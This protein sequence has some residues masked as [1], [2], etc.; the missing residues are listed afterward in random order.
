M[1]GSPTRFAGDWLALRAPADVAARDPELLAATRAY[2]AAVPAPRAID[3]G[4]GTGA[5]VA[6]IDAAGIRWRLL[7]QDADLLARARDRFGDSVETLIADIS[8][9]AA[10]PLAGARLVTASALLDL[11]TGPWV[12]ALADRLAAEGC[13]L[14]AALSYDGQVAFTPSLSGDLEMVAAFNAHQRGNKGRGLALGPDAVPVLVQV[15]ALR[16]FAVRTAPSP[17]RL[18]PGAARLQAEFIAGMAAAVG[19]AAGPWAQARS[20]M[21]EEASCIVG[22]VDLLALPPVKSQSKTTS[23]PSP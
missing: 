14:Y 12:E 7:D 15:L 11:M 9:P 23:V 17:W 21:V 2:L 8:D 16:G 6:A 10:L 19:G 22:H 13:G 3:L 4:A 20:A 18:G 1:S 5:T